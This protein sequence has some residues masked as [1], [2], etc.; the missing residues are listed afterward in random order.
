MNGKKCE[1]VARPPREV[2]H[3]D[4]RH[5]I[6]YFDITKLKLSK[7]DTI[8]LNIMLPSVNTEHFFK[9]KKGNREKMEVHLISTYQY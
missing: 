2:Y 9:V 1:I 6:P 3:K 8:E 4:F 5:P 7:G